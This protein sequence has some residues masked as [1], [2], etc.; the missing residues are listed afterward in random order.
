M[1]ELL[2]DYELQEIFPRQI[3]VSKLEKEGQGILRRI[4]EHDENAGGNFVEITGMPGSGKT[5][6]M[7]SF[8]NYTLKYHPNEKVYW[9]NSYGTPLQFVKLGEGK[10]TLLVESGSGIKFYNRMTGKE[11]TNLDVTYFDSFED[12]YL[13]AVPG[14]CN[15]VFFKDRHVWMEFVKFLRSKYGWHHIYIDEFGEVCPSDSDGDLWKRIGEF[16]I[17]TVGEVRKCCI[18][19]VYN[20]QSVA[21]I[22]YRP[23]R[24]LMIKIYLPG[25]KRD[26]MSRVTQKAIDRLIRDPKHGNFAYLD[27]I[28]VFGC[29]QF[30]DIFIPPA[31]MSLEARTPE[32][33]EEFEN[34]LNG[35]NGKTIENDLS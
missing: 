30:K 34:A 10:W 28:G 7:L 25:A 4:H 22:D 11:V 26:G 31:H 29:V 35:N 12:L 9:S 24:K 19:V 18:N 6:V 16:A 13:K 8:I 2:Q 15:A 14:K 27:A 21:D 32:M 23:R 20:T 17:R 5:S 3:V 1:D 33:K